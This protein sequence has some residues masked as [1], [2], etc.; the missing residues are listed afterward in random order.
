M[1]ARQPRA[2]EPESEPEEVSLDSAGVYLDL[3]PDALNYGNLERVRPKDESEPGD[4]PPSG[5]PPRC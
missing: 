2:D 4:H 5:G 1:G 3:S